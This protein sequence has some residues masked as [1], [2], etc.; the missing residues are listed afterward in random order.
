M[1]SDRTVS[2]PPSGLVP[3]YIVGSNTDW[4]QRCRD[5]AAALDRYEEACIP[6]PIEWTDELNELLA[7]EKR[8]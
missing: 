6:P 2:K 8:R 4:R 5:I 3:R 7:T 1:Y